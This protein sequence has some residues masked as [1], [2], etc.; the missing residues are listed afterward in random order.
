MITKD[1]VRQ[2]AKLARLKL[3]AQ[4]EEIYTEQLSK[5]LDYVDELQAVDT[6]GIEPMF[7]ALPLNNAMREDE[8][9]VSQSQEMILRGA[10]EAERGF[11]RVP[12]IGD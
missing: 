2:I 11:F 5:I 8:V 9:K 12:K 4:E 3:S 1:T 6:T 10:P 7:H